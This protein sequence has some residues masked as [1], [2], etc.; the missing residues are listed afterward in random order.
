MPHPILH[1]VVILVPSHLIALTHSIIQ[2]G[3]TALE[4]ASFKGHY[5][6]VE[7]LLGTGANPDLQNKVR[8]GKNRI[9][10]NCLTVGVHLHLFCIILVKKRM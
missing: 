2:D 5:K 10:I 4:A 9:L 3:E 7:L 6:V 8:T 1:A